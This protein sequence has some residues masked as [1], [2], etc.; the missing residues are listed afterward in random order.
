MMNKPVHHG[1]KNFLYGFATIAVCYNYLT[2]EE[3][4][5]NAMKK[6]KAA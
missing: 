5:N 3:Y 1:Q 4:Y 2:P 6:S